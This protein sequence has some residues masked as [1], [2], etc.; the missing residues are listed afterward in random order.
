MH[1]C[2]KA[3]SVQELYTHMRTVHDNVSNTK[4]LRL[5]L[6]IMLRLGFA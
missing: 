1:G 6:C 3:T 5:T 4:A 2:F